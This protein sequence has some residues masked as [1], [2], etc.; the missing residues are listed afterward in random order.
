[1]SRFSTF[2]KIAAT[3]LIL[4]AP[5]TALAAENE[6]ERGA[7]PSVTSLQS[8]AGFFT[9]KR[10][11]I[12]DGATPG[13]G[14]ATVW[15]PSNAPA[16]ETFGGVAVVPGFTGTE[17][18]WLGPRLAAQGFVVIT[19]NTTTLLDLPPARASQLLSA[20]NYLKTSSPAKAQVD[21][22]RLAVVGHSMGG[23]GALIAAQRQPALKAVV[24]LAG[25]EFA[26][27][28]SGITTPTLLVAGQNDFVASS[29]S[30]SS[31]F[32]NSIP[33]TTPK[34]FALLK[35]ADHYVYL[36]PNGAVATSSISW[37]KRYVDNDTRYT[38]FLTPKLVGPPSGSILTYKTSSVS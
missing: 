12:S 32:Y 16:G 20:L 22:N 17:L 3:A 19:F 13:F 9:V 11:A 29:A 18:T 34:A 27:T 25:F 33:T 5:S 38:Q 8:T 31:Q 10:T 1:M 7:D 24:S 23:G 2:A 14:T 21:P 30:H 37:L 4:A 36:N 6:F 26:K 28:F 35:G 15:A